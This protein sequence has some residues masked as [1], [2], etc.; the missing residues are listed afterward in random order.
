MTTPMVRGAVAPSFWQQTPNPECQPTPGRISCVAG[1]SSCALHWRGAGV[2]QELGGTES[3]QPL[4]LPASALS[5]V[6]A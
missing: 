1:L 3:R 4:E 5:C 6:D 2:S